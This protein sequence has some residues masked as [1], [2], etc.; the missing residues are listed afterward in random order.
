M[1]WLAVSAAAGAGALLR[2]VIDRAVAER[3]RSTWPF[4]TFVVNISGSFVLGML[5]GLSAHHG[6]GRTG[7]DIGGAGFAGG[8]TTL[9][10]W[11][12]ESLALAETREWVAA[13]AN[14][15]GSVAIGLLAAAAGL[16]L[17]L[18]GGS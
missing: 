13:T 6:L 3:W 7:L 2:Y 16:G 11:T 10:T 4:G 12:W 14:V 17:A 1:L 15:V 9:S 8:Y 18:C 5:V